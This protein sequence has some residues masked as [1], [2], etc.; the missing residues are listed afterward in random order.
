MK[1]RFIPDFQDASGS[2]SNTVG[3]EPNA[4]VCLLTWSDGGIPVAN[5]PFNPAREISPAPAPL[6][7]DVADGDIAVPAPDGNAT[8]QAANASRMIPRWKAAAWR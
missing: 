5:S 2:F 7:R 3:A 4:S 1:P 6:S 8:Y